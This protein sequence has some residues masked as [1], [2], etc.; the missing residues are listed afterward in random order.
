MPPK[1]KNVS[2]ETKAIA[3][4]IY[5]IMTQGSKYAKAELIT[6]LICE[7]Q[8]EFL[9]QIKLSIGEEEYNRVVEKC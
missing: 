1:K 6:K 4:Y 8:I 5:K 3:S 2:N 7:D 9:E